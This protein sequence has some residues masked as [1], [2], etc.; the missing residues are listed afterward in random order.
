MRHPRDSEAG[1]TMME[2]LVAM[3]ILVIGSLGVGKLMQVSYGATGFTR[4]ATEATVL[5]E[6]QLER[7][8]TVPAAELADGSDVVDTLFTRT[9]RV[10]PDSD[11]TQRITVTV[12]WSDD[13]EAQR[14][15]SFRTVR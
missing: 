15:I 10:V 11:G 13:G 12:T 9:W 3:V 1:F 7:L 4:R 14:A 6:D 2:L 5:G 8:R